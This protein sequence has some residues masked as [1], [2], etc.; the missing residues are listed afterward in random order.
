MR[1]ILKTLFLIFIALFFMFLGVVI[2]NSIDKGTS[3][4]IDYSTELI[5]EQ[6]KNVS[7]VL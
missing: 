7:N 5:Q 3:S 1:Q 4:Q 2:Y 6:L